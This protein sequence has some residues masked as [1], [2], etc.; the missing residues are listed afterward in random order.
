MKAAPLLLL[1]F[2]LACGGPNIAATGTRA[3]EIT[4]VAA[5]TAP[6]AAVSTGTAGPPTGSAAPVAP[7][8][9]LVPVDT[10]PDTMI[11]AA[12]TRVITQVATAV[13]LAVP[14]VA[15]PT[16]TIAPIPPTV[17]PVPPTVAPPTTVTPVPPTVTPTL[18]RPT[19]TPAPRIPTPTV[20]PR[21]GVQT[22]EWRWNQLPMPGN[23]RVVSFGNDG[24][25]ASFWPGGSEQDAQQWFIAHWSPLG[26]RPNGGGRLL[27]NG[28]YLLTFCGERSGTASARCVSVIT[29]P[30]ARMT[31]PATLPPYAPDAVYVSIAEVR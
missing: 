30:I 7:D 3:A 5:F 22:A 26:L 6:T 9:T 2:L 28:G 8:A 29:R 27:E 23:V 16:P 19:F 17:T 15:P 11:G 14:A 10:T 12:P 18:A 21:G 20:I 31:P 4:Q 13:P 1:L 24:Q 25:E